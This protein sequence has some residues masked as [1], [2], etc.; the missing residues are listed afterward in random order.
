MLE[1]S[2]SVFVKNFLNPDSK[3]KH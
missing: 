2:L 1:N 3:I